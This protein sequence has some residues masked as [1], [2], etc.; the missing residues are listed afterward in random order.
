VVVG[1]ALREL[2]RDEVAAESF[3]SKFSVLS[4]G[5]FVFRVDLLRVAGVTSSDGVGAV[6]F[7]CLRTFFV[8]FLSAFLDFLLGGGS[9]SSLRGEITS[10]VRNSMKISCSFVVDGNTSVF[11]DEEA[12]DS[13]SSSSTSTGAVFVFLGDGGLVMVVFSS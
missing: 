10:G 2:F 5:V 1:V 8:V 4:S 11:G 13:A 9:V 3:S 12:G 6:S 7:D